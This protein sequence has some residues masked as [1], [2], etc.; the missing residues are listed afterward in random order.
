M[1]VSSNRFQVCQAGDEEQTPHLWRPEGSLEPGF[2][3]E[4]GRLADDWEHNAPGLAQASTQALLR[5][6]QD[7]ARLEAMER[8][9]VLLRQR[10]TELEQR[11]PV[12]VPIETFAPE[13]Y[14]VVKPFHAVIRACAGEYV[15]SFFDANLSASGST[16]EEALTNLK[17]VIVSVLRVLLRHDPG[18]LGPGPARQ[19]RVLQEFVREAK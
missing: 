8:E 1:Q 18:R 15:A 10:V 17:D 6:W 7:T 5:K 11:A 16:Q 13:P 4:P 2:G 12:C 3:I 19:L 14:D 9:V